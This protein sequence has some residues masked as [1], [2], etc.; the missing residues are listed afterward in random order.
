MKVQINQVI[1]LNKM[2][3]INMVD[4]Q[5]NVWCEELSNTMYVPMRELQT[6]IKLYNWFV[7]QWERR[8]VQPFLQE[9]NGL[10]LD[11]VKAP[12]TYNE[13][14]F[15]IVLSKNG[16]QGIYPGP[17]VKDIKTNHYKSINSK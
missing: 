9:N 1:G 6:N 7:K 5:F 4:G 8:I 17:I 13:L 15:D 10:L 2:Q 14:F 11:G 16:M 12:E 3:Y